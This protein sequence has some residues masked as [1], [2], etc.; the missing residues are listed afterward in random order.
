MLVFRI[1][2]RIFYHPK[3]NWGGQE[4]YANNI[5]LK[6]LCF[7]RRLCHCDHTFENLWN[8][9]KYKEIIFK[10]LITIRQVVK[11]LFFLEQY[12]IS[13]TPPPLFFF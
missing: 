4:F 5:Y 11:K 7:L 12:Q 10:I 3:N 9:C 6:Y 8:T 1:I 13:P 2:S